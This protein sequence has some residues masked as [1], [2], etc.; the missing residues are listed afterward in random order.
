MSNGRNFA[1]QG[2]KSSTRVENT[3]MGI[4]GEIQW[5]KIDLMQQMK[6]KGK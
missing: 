1:G 2:F 5:I 3:E 6:A 4:K